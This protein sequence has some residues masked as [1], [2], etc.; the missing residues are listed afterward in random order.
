MDMILLF[1]TWFSFL[2][3]RKDKN[4]QVDDKV[5]DIL[6]KLITNFAKMG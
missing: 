1:D 4:W 6:S 3:E 2:R 5:R